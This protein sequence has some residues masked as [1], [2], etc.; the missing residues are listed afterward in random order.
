MSV[1]LKLEGDA[2]TIRAI[3]AASASQS[4]AASD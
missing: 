2:V 4:E 1:A 3:P